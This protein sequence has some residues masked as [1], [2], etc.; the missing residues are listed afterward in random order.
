VL[1]PTEGNERVRIVETADRWDLEVDW[2]VCGPFADLL[3]GCWCVQVFIDDIDGVGPTHGLIGAAKVP[4]SAGTVCEGDD[5]AHICFEY[6][7]CFPAGTVQAGVYD[8]VVVITL[9]A[10]SCDSANPRVVQDMLGYA[11]IPVLVF[12]DTGAPFCPDAP[13]P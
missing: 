4:V 13:I 8:L 10:C 3:C 1:D 7:F 5:T 9:S 11:Q 2:C 12:F 6:T